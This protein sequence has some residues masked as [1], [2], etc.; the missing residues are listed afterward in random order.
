MGYTTMNENIFPRASASL[1]ELFSQ[2]KG[3][4]FLQDY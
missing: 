1:R 2:E 3:Y 4:V